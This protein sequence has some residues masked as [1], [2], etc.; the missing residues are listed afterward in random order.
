M[1]TLTTSDQEQPAPD[2]GIIAGTAILGFVQL[3]G[4]L[5]EAAVRTA[6]AALSADGIPWGH[7]ATLKILLPA[8]SSDVVISP[9][10]NDA[11]I[12]L[13]DS[14]VLDIRGR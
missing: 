11:V 12:R 4:P 7:L 2:V 6:T 13:V 8:E 5:A 1:A 3:T 9:F 10:G 14:L